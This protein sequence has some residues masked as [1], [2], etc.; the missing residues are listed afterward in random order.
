MLAGSTTLKNALNNGYVLKAVPELI[1]EW[2][3]NRYGGIASVDNVPAD[4]TVNPFPGEFPIKSIVDP[5]RPRAGIIKARTASEGQYANQQW[6][7][8]QQPNGEGAFTSE[9]YSDSP[10]IRRYYT[11]SEDSIYK[12]WCSP[13]QSSATINATYGG[14]TFATG[15]EVQ[16]TV[17]Y[18]VASLTNK[19]VVGFENAWAWPVSYDIQT[20]TNGTTWTTVASNLAPNADG[21]VIVYRQANGTYTTT[22]TRG[23]SIRILGVR[24]VVRAMNKA[25]SHLSLIELSARLEMDL[26]DRL[27][28]WESTMDISDSNFITPLGK[29]SSNTGS[30]TL[31]NSDGYLNNDNDDSP[32]YHLIDDN[33]LMT[34]NLVYDLTSYGGSLESIRQ[35]TMHVENWSSVTGETITATLKDSSKFYQEQKIPPMLLENITVGEAVWR[36]CDAVGFNDFVYTPT[37]QAAAT[38]IPFFWVNPDDSIW[39]IFT[40]LAEATQTAIFFD[41]YNY[42]QIKTRAAAFDEQGTIDW[43]FDATDDNGKLADIITT[44][45]SYTFESNTVDITYKN[46][47][48]SDWQNGFP[49]MEAVWQPDT[50][51]VL[52]ASPLVV[53]ATASDTQIK[54]RQSDAIVWPYSGLFSINGE[55]IKYDAKKYQYY[56]K[57]KVA[58][59]TWVASK[60]EK[61]NVD[62]KL[63]DEGLAY[64]NAFTGT[65]RVVERGYGWTSPRA[66][67]VDVTGY[68]QRIVKDKVAATTATSGIFVSNPQMG[69]ARMSTDLAR[70]PLSSWVVAYHGAP[71]DEV[72][73]Y[74]GT[75]LRMDAAR[76]GGNRGACGLAF[77]LGPSESGYYVEVVGTPYFSET[78]AIQRKVQQEVNFYVRK[79]DGTMQRYASVSSTGATNSATTGVPVLISTDV[80]Y[81]LDVALFV[82][83]SGQHY[84]TVYINGTVAMR[85]ILGASALPLS[86]RYGLFTRGGI[87]VDYEYL[88]AVD[89]D[90]VGAGIETPDNIGSWDYLG[91]GYS[92][93]QLTEEWTYGVR[94]A[95]H[96]VGKKNVPYKQKYN[97]YFYDEFAPIAREVREMDVKF[98]KFPVQHSRIYSTNSTQAV[99][100]EYTPTPFGAKFFIAN[101]SRYNAVLNGEDTLYFGSENPITQSL[102]IYG[103]MIIQDENATETVSADDP[104]R[105]AETFTDTDMQTVIVK[106]EDRIRRSGVQAVEIDNRWIQSKG[107]AQALANW[108]I[109]HWS[110]GTDN[111]II[112][113]FG[114]P[115]VTIGDIVTVNYPDKSMEKATH[116]YFVTSVSRSWDNGLSTKYSLR[117]KA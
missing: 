89:N 112:S 65:L 63:S 53:S 9:D 61:D 79:T 3:H 108:I 1:A 5:N 75:K 94:T 103:R 42:L 88:Y 29:A 114:N 38:S 68:T 80:F 86:G 19:I 23:N 39:E 76:T 92:N 84:I 96:R 49:V 33:V 30:V 41:E 99:V 104:R 95:Y 2:N 15:F 10:T 72:P 78:G 34:L 70:F 44:E 97:Q 20:T 82:D 110:T 91:G 54:I 58:V 7:R 57:S 13:G 60:D 18:K 90:V 77:N 48:I 111:I 32:F 106:N 74:Y 14:Y 87:T 46:T 64:K 69:T 85:V 22:L 27:E 66:H 4:A 81:T 107:E 102:F 45:D 25:S 116:R 31:F 35:F 100:A 67:S 50:D 17:V 71:T 51:F 26:S 43:D 93:N 24:L 40:S 28:E 98:S 117:R 83:V 21:R 37:A 101:S 6:T 47:H 73:K 56:N 113:T 36:I 55:I 105:D 59:T 16:P 8:T 62:K 11:V 12:Y 115:L 52:R 109:N